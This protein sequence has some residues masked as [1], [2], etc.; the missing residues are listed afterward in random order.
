MLAVTPGNVAHSVAT[1]SEEH[2][3]Y[4]ELHHELDTLA[5]TCRKFK[6]LSVNTE[7]ELFIRYLWKDWVFA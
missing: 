5:V 4:V 2:E 6:L 1:T 3:R 7:E